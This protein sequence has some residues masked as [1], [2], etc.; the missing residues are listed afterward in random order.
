VNDDGS[1]PHSLSHGE[2]AY[3]DRR[4]F[5]TGDTVRLKNRESYNV[6]TIREE[7]RYRSTDGR[8]PVFHFHGD[9]FSAVAACVVRSH[10][11]ERCD[12]HG[13]RLWDRAILGEQ[14]AGA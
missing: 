7:T 14:P 13:V 9:E 11:I 8:G 4:G 6:G 12:K 1:R 3:G 5:K 10:E 2:P